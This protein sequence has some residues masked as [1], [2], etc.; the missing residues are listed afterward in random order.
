MGSGKTLKVLLPAFHC[1]L[2]KDLPENSSADVLIGAKKIPAPLCLVLFTTRKLAIQIHSE[3]IKFGTCLNI[4]LECLYG[5][6]NVRT[7]LKKFCAADP[8]VILC[9]PGRICNF[10]QQ[11]SLLLSQCQFIVLD[12]SDCMEDMGFEKELNS[13]IKELQKI[14]QTLFFMETWPNAVCCV[15][16][17]FLQTG[18]TV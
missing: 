1:I 11:K 16:N 9:T 4:R 8:Q 3:C 2:T 17:N 14:R 12:K 13:V 10:I 7:Q 15:A 5:S 18:D 6:T